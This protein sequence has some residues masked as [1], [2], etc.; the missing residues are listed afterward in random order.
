MD[1]SLLQISSEVWHQRLGHPSQ[2]K[3]HALSKLLHISCNKTSLDRLCTICPLAK[4]KRL[5][6]PHSQKLSKSPFDLVHIDIWGPFSTPTHEG[7]RY[8]L[9]IVDDCTRVTWIYLLKDKA[10]VSI[11]FPEFLQFILTQYHVSIKAI[12]S[13][14][15][16]EL[17]FKNSSQRK[18]HCSLLLLP[19]HSTTKLCCGKKAPTYS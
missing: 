14:N 3:I 16:P 13:D 8:F 11:V 7:F 17:S 5:S 18:I 12:R 19:L 9:T 2:D 10:S 6:F 4:Q 15:A 1:H